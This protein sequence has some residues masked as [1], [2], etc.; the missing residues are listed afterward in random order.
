MGGLT[1]Q[2][3]RGNKGGDK[4]EEEVNDIKGILTGWG[5]VLFYNLIYCM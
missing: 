3:R 5:E 1:G 4:E 2:G